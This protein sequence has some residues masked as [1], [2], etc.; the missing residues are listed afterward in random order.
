MNLPNNIEECHALIKVLLMQLET[1]TQRVKE[2]EGQ[3]N[4]NSKNSSKPPSMDGFK[5]YPVQK[6]K[7]SN[8]A[9]GGQQGHKGDTLKMID[10]PDCPVPLIPEVCNCGHNLKDVEKKLC[11]RRQV[12]DIPEPKLFV[13]EYQSFEC[14]CPSCG[15]KNYQPFPNQIN[16]PVQYGSGVKTLVTLLNNKFHLSWER[17]QELFVDLYGYNINDNTQKNILNRAYE[18]LEEPEDKIKQALLR[19]EIAHADETGARVEGQLKWLHG[20]TSEFYTYMFC[21]KKRGLKAM[22]SERSVLKEYTGTLVHDCLSS[23]FKFKNCDHGLCNSH[24]VRELEGLIESG[25][26]WAVNMQKLLLSLNEKVNNGYQLKKGNYYWMKYD[27]ICEEANK[28][29]PPP[30]KS[31]RGKPK[32]S[33][34]RNLFD[35]LTKYKEYVLKFALQPGIPFTNNQAER[36]IRPVKIKMKNAGCFRTQTGIDRYCR[37]HGFLSTMRKLNRNVFNELFHLF[38]GNSFRLQV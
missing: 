23:Y 16:A 15:Q 1:L 18:C 12:F 20:F 8:K 4:Q 37:I 5:K 28:Y 21:H 17:I 6:K 10:N 29:E 33:K 26:E 35:R 32:K 36:D 2:L 22:C 34:G 13:V 3:V 14:D 9:S 30:I 19:T 24:I 25:S 38:E 31:K 11:E 7:K 27:K